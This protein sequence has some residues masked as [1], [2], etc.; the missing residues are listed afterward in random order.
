MEK[1]QTVLIVEDE[2]NIVD[3]LPLQP[4][5]GR[6][7]PRWRPTT[8]PPASGWPWTQDPGPDPA[9][10]DA[11][12]RWTALRSARSGAGRAAPQP[13]S[14]CITAREEETD[15]VLGLDL[16]AD[17]YITKPF[18]IR[19]LLA[20]VKANIRR[21]SHGARRA[22]RGSLHQPEVL[23]CGRLSSRH[24]TRC[25]GRSRTAQPLQ[26]SQPREYELLIRILAAHAGQGL[27]PPGP[28]GAGVGLR[29]LCGRRARR[30][31]WPSAACGRRVEDDPAQS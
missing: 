21:V 26:L 28:D 12:R 25:S 7:T 30:W 9:G 10:P 18:S 8:A 31:T 20:R 29:G 24:G 3:I 1:Q 19:E 17:D 4:A 22:R 27:F 15:K 5:A 13:P 23:T 14:S 11:A 6:A 16:G 2:Q